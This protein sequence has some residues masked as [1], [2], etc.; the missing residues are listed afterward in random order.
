[1]VKLINTKLLIAILAAVT[2]LGTFLYHEHEVK[3]RAAEAAERTAALLQKQQD[4]A[5]AAKKADAELWRKVQENR[6]KLDSTIGN[7][8][9]SLKSYVP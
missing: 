4:D 8:S 2:A 1:M 5:E 7:G 9:K 6:K 3:V